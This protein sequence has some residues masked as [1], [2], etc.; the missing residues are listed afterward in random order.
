MYSGQLSQFGIWDFTT[1]HQDISLNK[2]DYPEQC[3][4]L[5]ATVYWDN[6]VGCYI[7]DTKV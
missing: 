3:P 6:G 1:F 5:L 2:G 7:Y 4:I